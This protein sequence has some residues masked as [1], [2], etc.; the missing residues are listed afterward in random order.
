[1]DEKDIDAVV[2]FDGVAWKLSEKRMCMSAHH[3]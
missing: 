1:M 3:E 2:T